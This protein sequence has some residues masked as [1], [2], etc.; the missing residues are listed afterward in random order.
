MGGN[1]REQLWIH[2]FQACTS[3]QFLWLHHTAIGMLLSAHF[4]SSAGLDF[5]Q[6]TCVIVHD[7][8]KVI[9]QIHF[10]IIAFFK[11]RILNHHFRMWLK[12]LKNLLMS[13]HCQ[14]WNFSVWLN[15]C[16]ICY[17]YLGYFT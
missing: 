5:V 14:N 17:C 1:N 9:V 4:L 16:A 7:A 8:I 3:G 15:F 11:K 12:H 2:I 10:K 13:Y 6:R